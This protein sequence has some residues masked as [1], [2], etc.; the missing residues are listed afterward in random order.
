MSLTQSGGWSRSSVW[1]LLC[2]PFVAGAQQYRGRA[3]EGKS[4]TS[5]SKLFSP[6]NVFVVVG[7]SL[8]Q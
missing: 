1:L 5:I 3:P 4:S 7:A 8:S 2:E 6:A